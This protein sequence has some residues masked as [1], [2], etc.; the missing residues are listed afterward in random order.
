MTL[1]FNR[2]STVN[3]RRSGL[4]LIV[5]GF[6]ATS[7][8]ANSAQAYEFCK[9]EHSHRVIELWDGYKQWWGSRDG[10]EVALVKSVQQ[11][12]RDY[13]SKT[14]YI[15]EYIA[16]PDGYFGYATE[17]AVR[18]LQQVEVAAGTV[19]GRVGGSV[20]GVLCN[21]NNYLGNCRSVVEDAVGTMKMN[22]CGKIVL[23]S[24]DFLFGLN[25]DTC[26]ATLTW[27]SGNG[28]SKTV[29]QNAGSDSITLATNVRNGA[30][31]KVSHDCDPGGAWSQ[32]EYWQ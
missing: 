28:G 10:V 7:L 19:D 29:K 18:Q 2:P 1:L 4:L 22:G 25:G 16:Y 31:F 6:L 23:Y 26:Q 30:Q 8:F 14:N 11:A 32:L 21:L 27:L 9:S 20:R 17:T 24:T 15:R 5:S 12:L 13:D 3:I